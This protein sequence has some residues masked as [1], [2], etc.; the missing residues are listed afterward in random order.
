MNRPV[1]TIEVCEGQE[2]ENNIDD[3]RILKGANSHEAAPSG[4]RDLQTIPCYMTL[5]PRTSDT[6]YTIG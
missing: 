1:E 3:Y 2:Q 6:L 5:Q 4:Y